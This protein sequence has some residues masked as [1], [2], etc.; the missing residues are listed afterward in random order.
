MIINL[1]AVPI[2]LDELL[3]KFCGHTQTLGGDSQTFC[4]YI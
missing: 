2:Y 3:K 1:F 4:D